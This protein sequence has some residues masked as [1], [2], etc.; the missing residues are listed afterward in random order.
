M[1]LGVNIDHVAT[2]RQARK[3]GFPSVVTAATVAL[4]AGADSITI[5]LREDRRHIQD[6]DLK[7]L[8]QIV[9]KLNLEIA[10]DANM[11]DIACTYKPFACCIVPEKRQELTTEGGLNVLDNT[12]KLL[13]WIDR[14]KSHS[15]QVSLFI[16]ADLTQIDAAKAVGADAIE[17]HTGTYAKTPTPE[18]ITQLTKAAQH[19][20][21]LGLKV[22]AGHGLNYDNV[23]P[24]TQIPHITELNIGFSIIAHALF[25]G[26]DQAVREMKGLLTSPP[27]SKTQRGC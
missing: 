12:E 14:L 10:S 16:D 2:V 23:I 21:A 15:I 17:I 18:L 1:H 19:A 6:Q 27:S 26:L 20:H 22:H 13:G 8:I 9:P 7:D 25:V 4:N 3:E 5:H 11:I 24:I